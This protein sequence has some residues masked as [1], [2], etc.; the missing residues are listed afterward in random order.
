M[1][2]QNNI[3]VS[4]GSYYLMGGNIYSRPIPRQRGRVKWFNRATGFGFIDI[5]PNKDIN[6]KSVFVYYSSI[7]I[8]ENAKGARYR[9]L[10]QGEEV[11]FELAKP[12]NDAYDL[13][14]V[15]VT[16]IGGGLLICDSAAYLNRVN[17]SRSGDNRNNAFVPIAHRH[18]ANLKNRVGT[19]IAPYVSRIDETEEVVTPPNNC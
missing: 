18:K 4:Y 3:N 12:V 10:V 9:Y 17:I 5:Y 1:G 11:E 13:H 14:A 8:N 7:L 15:N 19:Y 6:M 16:G 2:G